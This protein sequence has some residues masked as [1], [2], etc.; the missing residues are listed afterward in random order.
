M[1]RFI[2][3]IITIT[4]DDPPWVERA[5]NAALL[6]IHTIFRPWKSNEPLK[7]DDPSHSAN[8]QE[9]VSLPIA[10]PVWDGISIPV[11]YG[12]SYREKMDSLGT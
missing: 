1:D 7:Q 4:I 10:R 5:K 9:K 8:S 2:D 12:Y 11:L 3:D 6:I